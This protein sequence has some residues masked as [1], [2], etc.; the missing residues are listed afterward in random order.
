M[1]VIIQETNPDGTIT[2][3]PYEKVAERLERF[4]DECPIQDGWA[5]IVQ[6][7]FP[8][9]T[10]VLAEAVITDPEKRVV[11]SG[12]SEKARGASDFT[13][14]MVEW[15]STAA[16]GRA[17]GAAGYGTGELSTAEEILLSMKDRMPQQPV[18]GFGTQRGNGNNGRKPAPATR[19]SEN[20]AIRPGNG[21][22]SKISPKVLQVMEQMGLVP[23]NNPKITYAIKDGHLVIGGKVLP[24]GPKL[25]KAGFTWV[26]QDKTFVKPID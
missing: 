21:N 16:I 19:T 1:P 3:K 15:T 11:A 14:A 8:D 13:D 9:K 22:N 2:E 26:G 10:R 25:D 23:F 24:V 7:S 5:L 12:H 6:V 4:R 17:L 20:H 18:A